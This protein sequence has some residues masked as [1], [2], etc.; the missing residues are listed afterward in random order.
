M[1][2]RILAAIGLFALS[3]A[4]YAV[5]DITT[6]Q[7]LAQAQFRLLSDDLGAALSYKSLSPAEPLGITGFDLGV[8]LTSTKLQNPGVFK[9]AANGKN[10]WD[11]LPLA[12]LH[13][14]KGLPFGIDV[15]AFYSSVS[16]IKLTGAELK[17]ALLEGG[18]ATPAI[19]L[20]G[21]YT[22]LSGVKQLD[23]NTK[24]AELSISKGF[25]MLTPYAGVGKVWVTSTPL[26]EAAAPIPSGAGLKE[27]KFNVNKYYVGANLNLGLINIAIEGDKTGE[28]TTYGL[29][30]GMRF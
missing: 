1:Q 28:A 14:H 12:K 20:R 29:K 23:F 7:N 27:E 18:V 10:D 22:T 9:D 4:S 19:A 11:Q 24:G 15:G 13:A 17:Y 6:V 26:A 5:S 21:T 16:N 25:A 3:N 30:L 8:E 2:S